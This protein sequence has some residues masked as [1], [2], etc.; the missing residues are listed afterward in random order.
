MSN[1]TWTEVLLPLGPTWIEVLLLGFV[2]L[3]Q[4]WTRLLRY[5]GSMDEKWMLNPIFL[6]PV[7]SWIPLVYL[8]LGITKLKPGKPNG[9]NQLDKIVIF[10]LLVNLS[11]PFLMPLMINPDNKILSKIVPLIFQIFSLVIANLTRRY[12]NCEGIFTLDSIG[13]AIVDSVSVATL[14]NTLPYAVELLPGV[15]TLSKLLDFTT[16]NHAMSVMGTIIMAGLYVFTNMINQENL[17]T[18]CKAPFLGNKFD[19]I[20]LIIG[21]LSVII[22]IGL[23][24]TGVGAQVTSAATQAMSQFPSINLPDL[25]KLGL[26][27]QSQTVVSPR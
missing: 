7:F 15:N 3:G 12:F 17:D 8:K 2:P 19:K 4:I 1:L 22:E 5:N 9:T 18:L 26:L 21:V 6:F 16:K 13:K 27:A 10:P 14:S 24:S 23:I 25:T 11:L 20:P